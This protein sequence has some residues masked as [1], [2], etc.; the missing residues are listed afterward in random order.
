M[1]PPVSTPVLTNPVDMVDL[2]SRLVALSDFTFELLTRVNKGEQYV[3]IGDTED[4]LAELYQDWM[5]A[6]VFEHHH[7]NAVEPF[8]LPGGR[9]VFSSYAM[10][11]FVELCRLHYLMNAVNDWREEHLALLKLTHKPS[12]PEQ[13]DILWSLSMTKSRHWI[14]DNWPNW[15]KPIVQYTQSEIKFAI[16]YLCERLLDFPSSNREAMQDLEKF[17]HILM[18]HNARFFCTQNAADLMNIEEMRDGE[19]ELYHFNRAYA[20]YQRLSFFVFFSC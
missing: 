10:Q 7:Y 18:T 20:M 9:H 15:D 6:L 8:E 13:Y 4:Q 17:L 5:E 11:I 1:N 3:V 14:E 19:N 12:H 16:T 2:H